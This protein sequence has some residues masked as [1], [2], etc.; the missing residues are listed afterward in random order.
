MKAHRHRHDP[1]KSL[2]GFVVGDVQYAVPIARVREISNPVPVV[3]LPR[4]PPAVLGVADYRG[5]VVPVIDARMRFGLAA[6]PATRRTKWL[7]LDVRDRFVALLVDA[8]TEV[9]GTGG[10]DLRPAP[11]LGGGGGIRGIVGVTTLRDELVFVLEPSRFAE[12]TAPMIAHGVISPSSVAPL[13]AQKA[14]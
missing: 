4:A 2:V 12:L 11:P 10:T 6:V 14:S 1:S 7:I 3:T 8:V 13:I 5:D 9:F